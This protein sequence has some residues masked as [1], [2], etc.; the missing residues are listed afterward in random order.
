MLLFVAIELPVSK[1]SVRGVE[2]GIGEN[3]N[4]TNNG[5]DNF[6]NAFL[7]LICA[8]VCK[9]PAINEI[10][11]NGEPASSIH[12]APTTS[13]YGMFVRWKNLLFITLQKKNI[14]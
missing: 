14:T 4:L 9:D 12:L 10:V 5:N 7:G 8:R 11:P 6:V 1:A 3:T 2:A 13:S